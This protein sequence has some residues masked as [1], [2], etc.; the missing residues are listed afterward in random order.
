M[1]LNDKKVYIVLADLFCWGI[2]LKT[3]FHG[4][5]KTVSITCQISELPMSNGRNLVFEGQDK[6]ILY[7]RHLLYMF[8]TGRF[9]SGIKS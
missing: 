3:M 2:T 4:V 1:R 6:V 8:I 5:V 7:I 9:M